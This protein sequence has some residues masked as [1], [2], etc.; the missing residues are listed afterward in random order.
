VNQTKQVVFANAANKQ[1][2][3]SRSK[4]PLRLGGARDF[5][6]IFV[7][8]SMG[9]MSSLL[10]KISCDSRI[11]GVGDCRLEQSGLEQKRQARTT[12]AF[13]DNAPQAMTQTEWRGHAYDR[14]D[15]TRMLTGLAPRHRNEAI[16]GG[17]CGLILPL[18]AYG[19]TITRKPTL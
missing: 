10:G 8:A 12:I 18:S 1:T 7:F 14:P 2:P 17:R 15:S 5:P 13:G 6:S 19:S 11:S 4:E 16:T 3:G 9:V